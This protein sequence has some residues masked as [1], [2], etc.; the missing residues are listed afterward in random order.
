M[1]I[2]FVSAELIGSEV[3]HKLIK[4]GHDLKLFIDH[5][6]RKACFDGFAEKVE[7]WEA[8]L[9]WVGKDGLIIFDDVVFGGAQDRLRAEGYSVFG[10]NLA[11]DKLELDRQFF[12]DK[13]KEYGLQVLPAFEFETADDA[14]QF[15]QGNRGMWVLKQSSHIGM[16]NHVGKREDAE[17]ILDM[18]RIYKRRDIKKIQIQKKAVG[19]EV[20]IGRQFN[21]KKWVGP[22]KIN[23]EHKPLFNN[24]LGPLTAE[25]GTLAWCSDDDELPLFKNTLAKFEDYLRLVDYRGDFDINCIANEEG[26]WPLEA[27]MRFGTPS[28]ELHIELYNSP[29]GEL[30]KH[31]ADGKD[32]KVDYKDGYGI[33][34]SVAVPPFPYGPE[35]FNN[36]DIITCTGSTIFFLDDLSQD[37]RDRI[38]FEEVSREFTEDGK[39]RLY[40]AGKHGYA[41][42]VTGH[43]NTVEEARAHCYSV[44]EKI[45]IPKMFYR[46]DI[47]EDF[48]RG[49]YQKLLDWGYIG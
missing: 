16:L 46:T 15:V 41:L 40:L 45:Y 42:Y 11:G 5:P 36:S 38:H 48:I 43:G 12:Q 33:V 4:E 32:Y 29:W 21:G 37:E 35:N 47:G 19:V 31:V 23:F 9:D 20:G 14:I 10:G 27:T 7:D 49:D 24:D 25:M 44:V 6:D 26:I 17:D 18:L 8:E 13:L 3:I 34:V 39:E 2:L 30:L 1:R 22:A 28:T